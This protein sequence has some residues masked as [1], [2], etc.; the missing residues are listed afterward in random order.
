MASFPKTI[1]TTV[2][3]RTI[4]VDES[5]KSFAVFN[6]HDTQTIYIKE[7]GEVSPSNG[8]PVYAGG[9]ISLNALEDGHSVK[10]A[11]SF[12]ASGADT[13]CIIFEGFEE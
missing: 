5:R 8:I 11:W 13:P 12:I 9:N 4:A 1:G 10:E 7:G 3:I 2:D 6:T